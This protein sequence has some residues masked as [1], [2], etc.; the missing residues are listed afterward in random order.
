MTVEPV[1]SFLTAVPGFSCHSQGADS[2]YSGAPGRVII[3]SE[4][5]DH[6]KPKVV[7]QARYIVRSNRCRAESPEA[8]CYD[9]PEFPEGV[10]AMKIRLRRT[11]VAVGLAGGLVVGGAAIAG[12]ATSGSPSTTTTSTSAGS[13]P[14]SAPSGTPAERPPHGSSNVPPGS[15]RSADPRSSAHCSHMGTGAPPD[16]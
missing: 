8:W 12:A 15:T 7:R 13:S 6:R 16:T 14:T 5:R 3:G 10:K 11:L 4:S 9:H 1:P 2:P